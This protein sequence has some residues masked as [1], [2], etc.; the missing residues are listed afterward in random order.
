M[1][2]HQQACGVHAH[3]CYMRVN[4]DGP[5][6]HD[7][8]GHIVTRI[9][10]QAT[11]WCLDNAI[12]ANPDVADTIP[13]ISRVDHPPSHEAE[14]HDQPPTGGSADAISKRTFA[15]GMAWLGFVAATNANVFMA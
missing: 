4:I 8:A 9:G 6:H 7:L 13:A 14:Q 2:R 1:L 3:A 5:R 15:T 12:V 10:P 11:G